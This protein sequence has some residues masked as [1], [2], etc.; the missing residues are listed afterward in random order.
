MC[1][2]ITLQRDIPY[3]RTALDPGCRFAGECS[4]PAATLSLIKSMSFSGLYL[5]YK[6][7]SSV[8]LRNRCAKYH[9]YFHV[10][11]C[12]KVR[13]FQR[14]LRK[15]LCVLLFISDVHFAQLL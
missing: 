4:K 14:R 15:M 11:D 5:A 9:E 6:M 12:T 2:S 13:L 7:P 1:S 3:H 8:Y 10:L